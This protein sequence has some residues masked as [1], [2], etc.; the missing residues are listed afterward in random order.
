MD[1][2]RLQP[3]KTQI[4]DLNKSNFSNSTT[5]NADEEKGYTRNSISHAV[6][7]QKSTANKDYPR[8][9]R[10][11]VSYYPGM[12]NSFP[13]VKDGGARTRIVDQ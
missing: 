10:E 1:W 6:D 5:A 9:G 11:G 3:I 7:W 4:Q 13:T 8:L 12:K 2:L